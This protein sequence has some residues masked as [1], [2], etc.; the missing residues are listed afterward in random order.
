MSLLIWS[1]SIS[2]I[3]VAKVTTP[4][5]TATMAIK[6]VD[7]DHVATSAISTA[8]DFI[9]SAN[10]GTTGG[11][12]GG[13]TTSTPG[14]TLTAN[15][16][17]G[18]VLTGTAGN[19]TFHAGQNSVVMTGNGGS[20]TFIFDSQPW[21]AGH[22]TDFDPAHDTINVAGIL[23]AAGYTGASPFGDGTMSLA[24]DGHGGT[25]VMYHQAGAAWPVTVVD[26]DHVAAS[27]INIASDF[28]FHS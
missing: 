17:A 10:A 3:A 2:Q 20:D 14:I 5:S 25:F 7:L 13:T 1:P 4:T 16:T 18:Q 27:S 26:L 8:Q 24:N 9:T 6:I 21:N 11:T 15:N 12:T 23:S 28:I 19:D 22:I